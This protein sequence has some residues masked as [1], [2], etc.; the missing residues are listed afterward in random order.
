[1]TPIYFVHAGHLW[2]VLCAGDGCSGRGSG[3]RHA[4]AAGRRPAL[5]LMGCLPGAPVSALAQCAAKQEVRL[6]QARPR[7]SGMFKN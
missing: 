2:S 7:A 6:Q 4:P 5:E 1:M 3:G